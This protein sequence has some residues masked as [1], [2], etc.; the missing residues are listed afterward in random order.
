MIRTDV[1]ASDCAPNSVRLRFNIPLALADI[2][3]LMRKTY[4]E[5]N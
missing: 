1:V 5:V 2:K 3:E 4:D